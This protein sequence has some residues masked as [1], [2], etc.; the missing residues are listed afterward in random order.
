[1]DEKILENL[2]REGIKLTSISRRAF[3]FLI[4]DLI[5]SSLVFIIFFDSISQAKSPEE[6]ILLLNS[7]FGYI[8]IIKIIYHTFFVWQYGATMGKMLLKMQVVDESGVMRLDFTRSLIR[9]AVRIVSEG[10]FYLGF[11]W[12][13]LSPT[14]QT[15]HDKLAKS[16]VVDV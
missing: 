4:D 5:V 12:G 11:L 2:E 9:A 6:I 7:F 14:R 3:A 8:V 16:L 1:L 13:V 10:L 15:W